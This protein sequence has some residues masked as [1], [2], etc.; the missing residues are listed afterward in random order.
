MND[1]LAIWMANGALESVARWPRTLAGYELGKAV[2]AFCL[3]PSVE[4]MSALNQVRYMV[5][6]YNPRHHG[7]PTP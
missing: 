1:T 2:A 6:D 4:T 5:W 3:S 7:A